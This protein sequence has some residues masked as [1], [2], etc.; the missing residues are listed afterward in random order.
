MMTRKHFKAIAKIL[1]SVQ[2][3]SVTQESLILLN[4]RFADMLENENPRFD[5]G[6][7]LEA[8]KEGSR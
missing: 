1:S 5:R 4:A 3:D 7:F 2:W 8:C 6:K